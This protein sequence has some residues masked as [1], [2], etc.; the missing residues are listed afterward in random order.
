MQCG[1]FTFVSPIVRSKCVFSIV[2]IRPVQLDTVS[3]ET[4]AIHFECSRHSIIALCSVQQYC[5]CEFRLPAYSS[6]RSCKPLIQL[7]TG[8][9]Q[10]GIV[11]LW[12]PK[13]AVPL[14]SGLHGDQLG[15]PNSRTYERSQ[16]LSFHLCC[17]TCDGGKLTIYTEHYQFISRMSNRRKTKTVV[18]K[19]M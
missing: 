14:F 9:Y 10:S 18:R 3:D 16:S 4:D 15:F 7:K 12:F 2:I 1:H 6:A 11:K 13:M 19:R 5:R 8:S 17:L